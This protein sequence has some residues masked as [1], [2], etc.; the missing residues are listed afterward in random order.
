MGLPSGVPRGTG[1][2]CNG[3][4]SYGRASHDRLPAAPGR[5]SAV[6]SHYGG[7]AEAMAV[8]EAARGC[9]FAKK[10]H[11]VRIYETKQRLTFNPIQPSH[12]AGK[13]ACDAQ[14]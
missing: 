14:S 2:A 13:V 3:Q 6:R 1:H 10:W 4:A 5:Q 9:V 12:G 7:R 8:L 11:G